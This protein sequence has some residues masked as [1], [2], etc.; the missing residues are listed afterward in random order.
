MTRAEI[1][2]VVKRLFSSRALGWMRSIMEFLKAL[3]VVGLSWLIPLFNITWRVGT[4]PLNGRLLL[5]AI[6][7]I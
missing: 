5:Q 4:V 2:K 6:R 3:N 7:A 1:T